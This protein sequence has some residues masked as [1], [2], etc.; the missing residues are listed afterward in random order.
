MHA[1]AVC[2]LLKS[3]DYWVDAADRSALGL[4]RPRTLRYG[5]PE[6]RR[7][8][9]GSKSPSL[10]ARFGPP[11]DA[12]GRP[13]TQEWAPPRVRWGPLV[14]TVRLGRVRIGH[15][16]FYLPSAILVFG[17]LPA[18]EALMYRPVIAER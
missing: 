18:A 11:L 13:A 14:S 16:T 6:S 5:P 15:P 4:C 9:Q 12:Q 1:H 8:A 17:C 10:A 7:P 3:A 2:R